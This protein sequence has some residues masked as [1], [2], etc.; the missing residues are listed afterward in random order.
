M[1]NVEHCPPHSLQLNFLNFRSLPALFMQ[2]HDTVTRHH[3]SCASTRGLLRFRCQNVPNGRGSA[4]SVPRDALK[5]C[6]ALFERAPALIC[7]PNGASALGE[8]S[9]FEMIQIF[10]VSAMG[11]F[12]HAGAK[13]AA[14]D[15]GQPV[16][17]RPS[18]APPCDVQQAKRLPRI[19][20]ATGTPPFASCSLPS[21]LDPLPDTM[22]LL[23]VF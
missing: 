23:P 12:P 4:A 16:T 3:E 14:Q 10:L 22:L 21:L 1:G 6:A 2:E 7:L 19:P 13:T 9:H 5:G 20:R 17:A 18:A 15:S 11:H 8:P